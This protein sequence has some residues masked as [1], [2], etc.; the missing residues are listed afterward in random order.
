MV[1]DLQG[2]NNSRG[3]DSSGPHQTSSAHDDSDSDDDE[4]TQKGIGDKTDKDGVENEREKIM[5]EK[6]PGY[7]KES[8]I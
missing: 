7:P 3:D 8:Y 5:R 6:K 2:T 4:D 1:D